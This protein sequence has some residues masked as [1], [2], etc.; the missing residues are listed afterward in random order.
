MTSSNR[1]RLH[2]SLG[3]KL[4]LAARLQ[5][6]RLDEGL[7]GLGLTR[8]SWCILLAVGNEG[9]SQ[10]S[11]IARFVGIDRTA[12]SRALRQMEA[13]GLIAR[14]GGIGDRRTTQVR[15]TALGQRRLAEGTPIAEGNGRILEARLDPA[16][17]V[18]LRRLLDKLRVGED[19][20]LPR[21]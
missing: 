9:L 2:H 3:Y 18:E 21:L 13:A 7:R 10:P 5:E 1:Y 19:A 8:I 17:R 16:E 12:A 20:P 4:S 11:D 6:R 15:L 14:E